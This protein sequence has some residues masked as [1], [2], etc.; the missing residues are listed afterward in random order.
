MFMNRSIATSISMRVVSLDRKRCQSVQSG[1]CNHIYVYI[2]IQVY[3]YIYIN[4]CMYIYTYLHTHIN[5][6]HGCRVTGVPRPEK[7]CPPPRTLGMAV[8]QGP[9]GGRFL[10][11]LRRGGPLE[12]GQMSI[13][14]LVLL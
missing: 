3:M 7:N 14:K 13:I 1:G 6:E 2:Y 9:R 10:T 4:I 8:L 11:S 5:R 12:A